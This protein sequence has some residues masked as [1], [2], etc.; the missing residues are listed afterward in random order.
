MWSAFDGEVFQIGRTK[1]LPFLQ[2]TLDALFNIMMENS[3]SDT[4]DTLVFDSLVFIIGLI[5]DRKFQHFNPVL[6]TYIRKHFSAT[7]AYTKLTKVLK[8]YVEN[9]ER[10]TEQLLKAMKAL[11]YIF[12]F[13]VRSRVLFN[14]L[15]E[16]KGEADFM[17]S[18][19][20]LFTSFNEMMNL[21]SENT[22]MVKFP[23]HVH[24]VSIC[25]MLP[26]G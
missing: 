9:A 24:Y 23:S 18:L 6:E 26:Y 2:D 19:R 15:Y 5:S 12:K 11:E 14:Q 21:N 16:N 13:I 25:I 22:G 20:N 10:L 8:N 1:G 7:L 3:D 4:F 17:E